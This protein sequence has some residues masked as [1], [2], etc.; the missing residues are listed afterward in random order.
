MDTVLLSTIS[1]LLVN[2]AAGWFGS[3]FVIVIYP[4]KRMKKKQLILTANLGAAILSLVVAYIL[5]KYL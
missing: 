1:D 4:Q 5:R 3:I 2:L